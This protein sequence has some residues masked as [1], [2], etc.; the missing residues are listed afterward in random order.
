[1]KSFLSSL[2][3]LLWSTAASAQGNSENTPASDNAQG[4]HVGLSC[5]YG[6]IVQLCGGIYIR[7]IDDSVYGNR[8]L[9]Q[10]RTN[11]LDKVEKYANKLETD[12]YVEGRDNPDVAISYCFMHYICFESMIAAGEEHKVYSCMKRLCPRIEGIEEWCEGMNDGGAPEGEED[13]DR[14][15]L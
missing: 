10:W 2:L 9:S 3:L 5:T 14:R 6:D 7:S 1:M 11:V 8:T 4:T 13:A 15:D 12:P